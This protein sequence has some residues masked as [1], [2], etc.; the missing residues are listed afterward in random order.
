MRTQEYTITQICRHLLL[1]LMAVM[2]FFLPS[3]TSA[4]NGDV[5]IDL[6]LKPQLTRAQVLNLSNVGLKGRGQGAPLFD[7]II[8]NN[9]KT[10]QEK[11]YLDVQ[12]RSDKIGLIAD[13]YQVSGQP[14]SL[15]PNQV[16]T[17]N[18]NQLRNGLPGVKETISLDGGLT[19]A[20]EEF[21][22]SLE[23]STRLPGDIYTATV[24]LYQGNNSRNGGVMIAMAEESFGGNLADDTI[25]DLYLLQPGG[26]LG[27]EETIKTTLPVFRWDGAPTLDYRLLVVEDNGQSPEALIQAALSSSPIIERNRPAGG[28]L[29]EFEIVDAIV[30]NF[31]YTLPPSGIQD[32]EPGKRYYWQVYTN[33]ET[34]GGTES[35]PSEIWEFTI[36]SDQEN[37]AAALNQQMRNALRNLLGNQR[38]NEL[39]RDGFQFVS[40]TLDGQTLQGPDALQKLQEL[41][42]ELSSGDISIVIN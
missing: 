22:N 29:L 21:I 37:V 8:R 7:L 18:N 11:L 2:L 24:S 38:Y 4:Q 12:I 14:F 30:K 36:T 32:L 34:V 19:D 41:S 27:S 3:Q 23:G 6:V 28:S 17:G 39:R 5:S 15:R 1:L 31:T 9:E 42:G 10:T 26:E 40:I 25:V 33:R 20:G 16:V 35:V 13:L